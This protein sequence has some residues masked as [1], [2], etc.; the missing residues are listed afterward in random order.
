[1]RIYP[2]MEL[3]NRRCVSL[4]GGRLE[5]AAIWHV[6]PVATARSWAAA[7]AEWMHL[8]DFDWVTGRD[9]NEKLVQEIIR[10]V[11]IPV[12]LA[13]GFRTAEGVAHWIDR[14]AGRI[15]LSTL[16][17]RDPG[18][19]KSLARAYPDQIVLSVDVLQGHVMLDGWRTESSWSPADFIRAFNDVPLA[20]VV[21]TDIRSDVA[22]QDA[23]L[24]LVSGL[25]AMA[26]APV[27]ASGVVQTADDVARLKYVPN[28]SG[29]LVG[30]ALFRKTLDLSEALRTARPEREHV[31]EFM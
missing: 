10:T 25:A 6:D 7:G 16:A 17:A 23:Q 31:A 11:G 4:T 5:D 14:G 12:Q 19:F 30:R 13:G 22:D 15:V 26:K 18:T 24:S 8:T 9:G 1:M 27:I 28:I 3:M 2:T 29:A 20:A 21:V